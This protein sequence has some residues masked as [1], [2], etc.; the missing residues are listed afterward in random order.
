MVNV[1]LYFDRDQKEPLEYLDHL[2]ASDQGY[3]FMVFFHRKR[4][5]ILR[6]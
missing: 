1:H 3:V 6:R 4:S 2:E 5:N